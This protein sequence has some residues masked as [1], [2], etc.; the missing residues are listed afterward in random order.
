MALNSVFLI[1]GEPSGDVLAAELIQ[2]FRAGNPDI[3]ISY[4]GGKAA[5]T[6]MGG[7]S[8]VV[9]MEQMAFMGF[10]EVLQHLPRVYQ[11]DRI[12]KDHIRAQ[13]PDLVVLIDYPGYNLRLARWL[14]VKGFRGSGMKVVQLVCPQFW[15][16]KPSR[17]DRIKKYLDAVYPLLP[18][19]SK[20]L[21]TAGVEAPYFGH[22]AAH[23]VNSGGYDPMGP[24]A[25]L[26]G[27]R[28]QE[29][30]KHVKVFD[31]TARLIGRKAVWYRPSHLSTSEYLHVLRTYGVAANED[32]IRSNV[33]EM[34]GISMALVASGTATLEVALRGIPMVVAYK[35]TAITYAIAKRL[36][37][38]PYISLVN[39]ILDRPVVQECIQG[40][41]VPN[42]LAHALNDA[43][44]KQL[45]E[46]D[47]QTLR[48][49]IALGNPM[50]KIAQH[51]LEV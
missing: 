41:C 12:I 22:P 13:R 19:E 39:L 44:Q 25:L 33:P 28:L 7:Q 36:I 43:S 40:E 6:A 1:A 17:L 23:R 50:P 30:G 21:Q 16:W 32:Q 5:E 27:S 42:K 3:Q 4:T 20:L 24:I 46:S 31:E 45:W 11:N 35:T 9:P 18:F 34:S 8:P 49:L 38:V 29:W 47:Y 26:P 15:A 51:A 2:A 14:N 10:W 48:S 37:R